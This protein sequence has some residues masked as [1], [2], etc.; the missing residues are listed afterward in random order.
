MKDVCCKTLLA[1]ILGISVIDVESAL[2]VKDRYSEVKIRKRNGGYRTIYMPPA[3]LKRIQ[4]LLLRIFLPW[5]FNMTAA[6][7]IPFAGKAAI[8]GLRKKTG[9]FFHHAEHHKTSEW[10]FQIDL[11]DAFPSADINLIKKAIILRIC[12]DLN[13]FLNCRSGSFRKKRSNVEKSPF[14]KT[15]FFSQMNAE[16]AFSFKEQDLCFQVA[17][18]LASLIIELT[19]SQGILP[20]GTPT[21]SFLFWINLKA[22]GIL[23]KI[24]IFL[25]KFSGEEKNIYYC[26]RSSMYAD[27]IVVSADLNIP[28]AVRKKIVELVE[29]AEF[30][31]NPKKT[32]YQHKRHGNVLIT[33]LRVPENPMLSHTRTIKFPKKTIR[34]WRGII[35]RA[36]ADPSQRPK[37]VGI[38]GA[39]KAWRKSYKGHF[40]RPH[41]PRQIEQPY[42]KLL[43]QIAEEQTPA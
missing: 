11:K 20:Q 43:A 32:F 10:F 6:S 4:Q 19:T 14:S 35:Y 25:K 9:S 37:V 23:S 41:I 7:S 22:S 16:T 26:F 21:A 38:M 33:G 3:P 18:E 1:E 29:R 13:H 17:G 42:E 2:A 34:R 24:R 31:V 40:D 8:F 12:Y 5:V 27:N 39:L 28:E 30:K 36:I 15:T